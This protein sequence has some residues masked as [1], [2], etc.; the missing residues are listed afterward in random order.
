MR[1]VTQKQ[2]TSLTEITGV[3]KLSVCGA[4]GI[5]WNAGEDPWESLDPPPSLPSDT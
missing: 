1:I 4:A 3:I 2:T 5:P